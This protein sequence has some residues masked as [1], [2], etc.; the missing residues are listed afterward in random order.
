MTARLQL[1]VA[2]RHTRTVIDNCEWRIHRF[3]KYDA[4]VPYDY[5]ITTRNLS[6]DVVTRDHLFAINNAMPARAKVEP[7]SPF[8]GTP[9]PE[10]RAISP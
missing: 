1:P 4:H 8:L 9:I 3:V 6:P 7:W 2:T 5:W 10:L